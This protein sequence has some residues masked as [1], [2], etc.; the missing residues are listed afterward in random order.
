VRTLSKLGSSLDTIGSLKAISLATLLAVPILWSSS[1]LAQKSSPADS[2]RPWTEGVSAKNQERALKIFNE[3]NTFFETSQYALATEQ[4]RDALT[5][6]QHPAIHFNMMVCL[7]NLDQPKQAYKQLNASMKWGEVPLGK[8]VY[9]RAITYKKLLEGQLTN[10]TI[11]S[12]QDGVEV[13]LDG[14]ALFTSPGEVTLVALPGQHQLVA[15]KDGYLTH[16]ENL[17]YVG[18]E[19]ASSDVKLI[20]L[21]EAQNFRLE[22]RWA[23]WKP[24][25]VLGGGVATM[26]A[27]LGVRFLASTDFDRYDNDVTI[28]CPP[29]GCAKDELPQSTKD[30]LSRAELE[31]TISSALLISGGVAT[32][33]GA[34]LLYF[35]RERSIKEMLPTISPTITPNGAGV[36][37]TFDID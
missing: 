10:L 26:A 19:P 1:A 36:S 23:R 9:A 22:R 29:Q 25:T 20:P 31:D 12:S 7:I 33:A 18:G 15:S 30:V 17:N 13:S 16:T 2:D 28:L 8:D 27:G 24:W 34:V 5:S 6:W 35:N 14:K 32:A 11:K 37:I 4:Y 21:A 3:G